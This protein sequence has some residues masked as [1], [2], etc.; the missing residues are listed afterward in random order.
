MYLIPLRPVA[1]QEI[2]FNL[3]GAYWQLSIKQSISF[4]IATVTRNGEAIVTG[5]RCFGGSPL[6]PYRYMYMPDYG[7][8]VFDADGDYTQFG[9]QC[10]LY[11][12]TNAEYLQYE[13][14]LKS[15]FVS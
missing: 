8:F 13:A 1:N 2:A 14:S 11:Y 7:N 3:D 6:M 9:G 12:L 10:N 5:Q 15:G 4:M